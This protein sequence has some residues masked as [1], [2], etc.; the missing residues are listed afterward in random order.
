MSDSW[1]YEV[2]DVISGD[3]LYS[4]NCLSNK[5][6]DALWCGNGRNVQLLGERDKAFDEIVK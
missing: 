6:S 3:N 4:S 1:D 2:V 5:T